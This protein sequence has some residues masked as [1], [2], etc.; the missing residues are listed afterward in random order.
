MRIVIF[1]LT[2]SSTWG[3]GHATLWRSL[4]NALDRG[5]HDV[6][7]YERDVPYYRAHRDLPELTGRAKLRLYGSRDEIAVEAIATIDEADAAV[8]TSYW[9]WLEP[10]RGD[11][12]IGTLVNEYLARGGRAFAVRAGSAYVDVGTLHGWRDAVRLLEA[13]RAHDAPRPYRDLALVR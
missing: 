10:G 11:T 1:G 4:I 7:F 6:V 12:Y 9:L 2:V 13:T 8:V 3:N 5:G